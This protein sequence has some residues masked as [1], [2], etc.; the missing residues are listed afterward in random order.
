MYPYGQYFTLYLTDLTWVVFYRPR[1]IYLVFS[2]PTFAKKTLIQWSGLERPFSWMTTCRERP[3]I[4][5][6][7]SYIS[8][9]INLS[10]KTTWVER[11]NFYMQWGSLSTQVVVYTCIYMCTCCSILYFKKVPKPPIQTILWFLGCI[12]CDNH[13]KLFLTTMYALCYARSFKI[14]LQAKTR[15]L[16]IVYSAVYNIFRFIYYNHHINNH[17]DWCYV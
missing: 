15:F 8:M 6:R 4:L 13:W 12:F 11:P 16:H 10:P 5:G 14:N 2:L 7:R 9:W 1:Y 17:H 3:D